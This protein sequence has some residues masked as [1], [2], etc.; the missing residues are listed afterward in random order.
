M[1]IIFQIEYRTNWGQEVCVVGADEHLGGWDTLRPFR[2]HTTDGILWTGTVDVSLPADHQLRYTYYIY[3]NGTP[4]RKEWDVFT[5]TLLLVPGH[6]Y[7]VQDS[8]KDVPEQ[9]FLYSSAFTDCLLERKKQNLPENHPDRSL[10]IKA[11]CPRLSAGYALAVCGNQEVLGNWDTGKAVVMN[12]AMFPEW[13]LE[14]DAD[15]LVY[16]VEYKFVLYN[17]KEERVEDWEQNP[18]RYIAE[19]LDGG[20]NDYVLSDRH[21]HFE[22]P[23]WKGAGVAIPVFSLRSEGSFGIGDFGDLRLMVDWAIQTHQKVVQVLPVND[24]TMTHGWMD[25]YPYNGISIYALNPMYIDLRQLPALENQEVKHRFELRQRALNALSMLDYESVDKAKWEYLRLSFEQDGL[26]ILVSDDFRLFFEQNKEW[27]M[28][29]AAYCYLRDKNHTSDFRNWGMYAVYRREDIEK[30]CMPDTE[31][32]KEIA[33]H[34]YVQYWLHEQLLAVSVYAR[35]RGVILKGDI[36]IGISRCSVEAWTEP[37]Y[38]NMNGQ[39]G[40]PP[41]AFSVNGQNW[42]FPTYNWEVMEQDGYSWWKKRF[43]K[44]ATYFDAYRID[45]ILGFFRI[46]EIPT[47]AV[48]GLLGQ[49]VPSLPLTVEE[50]ESYGLH[51]DA[52]R[53]LNPFIDETFIQ[54]LFGALAAVVKERFLHRTSEEGY[55]RLRNEYATQRQIETAF[56]GQSDADS[57]FIRDGLYRLVSNV[58]FLRDVKLGNLYH[59]RISVQSERTYQSLSEV[60]RHAFDC[61]YEDYFYH[62]HNNFWYE[63]AMKKLP[64][65]TQSTRMLVC[66]EDLGMIPG[67]VARVMNELQILSLEIQRMPK[68]AFQEFAHLDCNPYL[69]VTTFSTHDMSTLRGWWREDRQQTC[70]FYNSMLGYYGMAPAEATAEICETVVKQH[71]R[72][73]SMLCILSWQDWLSINEQYRNVDVEAERINIPANPRHY[74]RYRMHLTLEQL[75]HADSLNN[76]I[77]TLIDSTGRNLQK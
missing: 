2:L 30:L 71:L 61:L 32:Y 21:V 47:H 10:M 59:P 34:Y 24:T 45:H 25:S 68:Q 42:G 48:H 66:G 56:S 60:D 18:N 3:E 27:L 5:R 55:Y 74:W 58:L 49:F 64:V 16:P 4:V 36:P 46:W 41:D 63:Q 31:H 76:Q 12:D 28:P 51:W 14:L 53:F 52:D 50:I 22:L 29:Y 20:M 8:W 26:R 33:L 13:L 1:K 38:F 65:L 54:K 44:M 40:A 19:P 75:L 15:K 6:T 62:R 57:L 23:L 7:T 69:S 43:Q 39:A 11:Y 67:C 17:L 35:E 70:R 72:G 9:Q 77:R 37:H 73:N